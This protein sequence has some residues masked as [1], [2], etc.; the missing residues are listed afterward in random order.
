MKELFAQIRPL[1]WIFIA[2]I[3]VQFYAI[4][5]LAAKVGNANGSIKKLAG[6]LRA[7]LPKQYDEWLEDLRRLGKDGKIK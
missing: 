7:V 1:D 5:I 2:F 3:I 4:L 6:F